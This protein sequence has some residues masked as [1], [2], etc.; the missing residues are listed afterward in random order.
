MRP[1]VP[2]TEVANR[3]EQEGDSNEE[4]PNGI[5]NNLNSPSTN[6]PLATLT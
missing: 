2:I 1:E 6:S 4:N 5:C 3:V